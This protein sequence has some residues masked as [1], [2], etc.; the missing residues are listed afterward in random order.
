[1]N[2]GSLTAPHGIREDMPC[3]PLLLPSRITLVFPHSAPLE[4]EGQRTWCFVYNRE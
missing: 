2:T 1:M 3:L 4:P